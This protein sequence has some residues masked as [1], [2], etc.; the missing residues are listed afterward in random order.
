MARASG[1]YPEG[2]W[3]DSTRRYH[4]FRALSSA[5]RASALQ[6]EG[7]RFE[8]Y[9]AHHFFRGPVV[10]LVRMPACHAGGRRFE[11]DPDRHFFFNNLVGVVKWS[12]HRVV[13]PACVGSNP[14]A[15]PISQTLGYSQAVRQRILIPSFEGSNPSTLANKP[16]PYA[17]FAPAVCGD[18]A[19]W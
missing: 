14:I 16:N 6:A 7:H 12:R 1:S 18:I 9:S 17:G 8:P 4:F 15:H 3:F 13:A 5:G 2:R 11:P 19:K 10:Q